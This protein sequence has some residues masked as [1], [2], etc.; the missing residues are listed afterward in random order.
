MNIWIELSTVVVEVFLPW[1]F[2][3]GMLGRANSSRITMVIV[4]VTYTAAL[5]VLSLFIPSSAMRSSIIMGLTYLAAKLYFNKSWVSTIYPTIMFFLFAILSDILCGTLLQLSGVPA[6]ALM[7]DGVDRLIYVILG[8]LLHLLC[9]YIV[10]TITKPQVST[11]SIF[12]ALPLLSCQ[13]LST[14][15]CQK[16]F[17]IVMDGNGPEFL[18][19][20]TLGILYINLVMCVFVEVLNR[21]HE[22]EREAEIGRQQL[23]LQKNYYLDIMERQEETR[24]L[25]HDIKKYMA[26]MEAL[27]D[28]ENK[29]EAQQCLDN[30][31]STFSELANTVD[32][33]NKL[34]DSILTY[35]VKKA[36]E[37]TVTIQP[38]IWVDSKI[39]FPATDLFVII[40]N[41]LDNAIEACCQI[42]DESKRIV[43]MGLLQKNH[44]LFYEI[45][46]P[47][48]G[49]KTQKSG[50]IHGYGLKNVE[51]CVERNGGLM[52]ISKENGVFAVSIQLN[53]GE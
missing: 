16:N 24:S 52:S 19:L 35:G 21:S 34:I 32:T 7:G 25:W 27:V 30:I 40:G 39:D 53:L 1:Y 13:I 12:K 29:E 33:G 44:L 51:A 15:I 46:N 23:E 17:L 11:Q 38:E 2:F 4:G 49:K 42:E 43:S 20:E 22:R 10:L 45:S 28:S 36:E 14:Y 50:R 3:S 47:Y 6:D 8:K 48:N 5:A 9:L 18:R 26:T 31:Q 37:L 41:T